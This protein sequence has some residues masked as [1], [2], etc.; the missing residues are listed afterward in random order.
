MTE[1]VPQTLATEPAI[2]ARQLA[3]WPRVKEVSPVTSET[4]FRM[5][6]GIRDQ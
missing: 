3:G 5:T 1:E 4:Y 6:Q 2:R